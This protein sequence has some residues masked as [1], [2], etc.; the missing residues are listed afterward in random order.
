MYERR[1][2]NLLGLGGFGAV[3]APVP[4]ARRR[5]SSRTC[6]R[7]T[8]RTR[9]SSISTAPAIQRA[10]RPISSYRYSLAQFIPLLSLLPTHTLTLKP[11]SVDR[12]R[13]W[14][15]KSPQS[16]SLRIWVF[17]HILAH[18]YG[19]LGPCFKT[20]H[21]VPCR[22]THRGKPINQRTFVG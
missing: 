18:V 1:V 13:S 20:G 22:P 2:C 11:L 15:L 14:V 21:K 5:R 9:A 10:T 17:A 12:G 7:S 3:L 8:R 6:A 4:R 16:L 19:L